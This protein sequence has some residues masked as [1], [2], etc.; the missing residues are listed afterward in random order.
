MY[1]QVEHIS[2][3]INQFNSF[4]FFT[5]DI[6]FLKTTKLTNTMVYMGYIITNFEI[7]EFFE[8]N[9]LLF[10]VTIF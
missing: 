7:G 4:L 6:N 9:G 1:T 3:A 8:R 10:C 2:L 5:F